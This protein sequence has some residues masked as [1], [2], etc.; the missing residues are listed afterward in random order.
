MKRIFI[1]CCFIVIILLQN[2]SVFSQDNYSTA[3]PQ[4]RG[5]NRNGISEN[6]GLLDKWPEKGPKLAWKKELGT[7]FSELIVSSGK[8]YTMF[9]D[10][11]KSGG[12][13]YVAA[14]D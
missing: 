6:T 10:T 13:E 7:G 8:V 14:F 3:W 12:F 1:N 11:A 9:G 2:L 4:F 5:N